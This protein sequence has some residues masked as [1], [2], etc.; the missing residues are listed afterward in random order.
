MSAT[1][2][3][4]SGAGS[5]LGGFMQLGSN[6]KAR[7]QAE[8]MFY[9]NRGT[10]WEHDQNVYS[11]NRQDALIDK[12]MEFERQ[13]HFAKNSTKWNFDQLMESA[14][15]SGIHRLSALSGGAGGSYTPAQGSP[16]MQSSSFDEPN[17]AKDDFSFIG[18]AV[19]KG[20]NAFIQN[21]QNTHAAQM[22]KANLALRREE[23]DQQKLRTATSRTLLQQLRR[24]TQD[25]PDAAEESNPDLIKKS[26]DTEYSPEDNVFKWFTD[27]DAIPKIWKYLE[28]NAKQGGYKVADG[29][30]ESWMR[31]GMLTPRSYNY[32]SQ[33]LQEYR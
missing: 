22:D 15:K 27:G 32:L 26:G 4:I 20:M 17:L 11:R 5:L 31:K 18:D 9:E 7:S 3:A 16:Q 12:Q 14:D 13:E 29:I 28:K 25:E 6:R 33:K 21:Q 1:A 10:Q 30:L 2:A 8:R 19:S 23:L 24:R